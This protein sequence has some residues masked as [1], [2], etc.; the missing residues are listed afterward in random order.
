MHLWRQCLAFAALAALTSVAA[1]T[2][3]Y[4]WTDADGVVHFSDQPEPG[5]E[6]VPIGPVRTYEAPKLKPQ[7]KGPDTPPKVPLL[8]L[9]YSNV[10]I[11]SPAAAQT[12]FDEPVPIT[13]NL[14]P[15]L[16]PGHTLTWYLNGSPLDQSSENFTIDHLDRGTY[17]ISAT[18]TDSNTQETTSAPPVTFYVHQPSILSPQHPPVK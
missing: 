17:T 11:S 6:K 18:I 13:L 10:S 2:T 16:M 4:R 8:H 15:D 1:A 7:K 12:F 3:V 14:A 9:G 5:A